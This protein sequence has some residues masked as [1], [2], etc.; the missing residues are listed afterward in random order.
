MKTTVKN[1]GAEDYI[2]EPRKSEPVRKRPLFD[3]FCK[4]SSV[5]LRSNRSIEISIEEELRDIGHRVGRIDKAL[6]IMAVYAIVALLVI[7]VLE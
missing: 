7:G 3:R 4:G 1:G 5:S 6:I 2:K